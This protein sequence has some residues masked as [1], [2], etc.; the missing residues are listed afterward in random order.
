MEKICARLGHP[1]RSFRSIIVAGTNGKGSVTAM[2][3]AA[4][5]AAGYRSARYTSP[6]LERIEERFVIDERDVATADLEAA[7]ATVQSVVERLVAEG[8]LEDACA[9]A[10]PDYAVAHAAREWHT[11]HLMHEDSKRWRAK[12]KKSDFDVVESA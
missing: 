10:W 8:V 9:E 1:E 2:T 7:A 4:L 6:H 12:V 11:V 5:Q 3:S